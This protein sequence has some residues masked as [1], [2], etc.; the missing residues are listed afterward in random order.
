MDS[1]LPDAAGIMVLTNRNTI[2]TIKE[3]KSNKINIKPDILFDS[4]KKTEYMKVIKDYFDTVPDVPNTQIYK[5]CKKLFCD[6]SPKI[7]HDL[8]MKVLRKR[9]NPQVLQE[10]I[11]KAPRSL[12][13]YA[14]SICSEKPKMQAL[15]ERLELSVERVLIPGVV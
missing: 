10:F 2:K 1:I 8:T 12:Y 13:A 4:L 11:K 7:T 5:E 14:M 6:I 9:S 3:A 15:M